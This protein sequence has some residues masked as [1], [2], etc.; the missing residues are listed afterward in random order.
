VSQDGCHVL[1][2]LHCRHFT[3]LLAVFQALYFRYP[4]GRRLGILRAPAHP[5]ARPGHSRRPSGRSKPE[6]AEA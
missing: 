4:A 6:P 5:Q 2:L 3:R 1:H